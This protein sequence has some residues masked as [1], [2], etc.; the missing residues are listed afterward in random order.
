MGII[1]FVTV[2]TIALTC[3][4][5]CI[6]TREKAHMMAQRRK[7]ERQ[8]VTYMMDNKEGTDSHEMT[9]F[10][11]RYNTQYVRLSTSLEPQNGGVGRHPSLTPTNSAARSQPLTEYE[12]LMYGDVTR[13]DG[14]PEFIHSPWV[15]NRDVPN[16]VYAA[17]RKPINGDVQIHV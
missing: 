5:S 2:L 3:R 11:D 17:Q 6:R 12:N 15:P 13:R 4:Q 7:I 10:S 9:T 1:I 8:A 14:R 16:P